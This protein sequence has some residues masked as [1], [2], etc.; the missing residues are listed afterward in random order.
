MARKREVNLFSQLNNDME[1]NEFLTSK[2][3]VGESTKRNY[4][5]NFLINSHLTVLDVYHELVGPCLTLRPIMEKIKKGKVLDIVYGAN[6]PKIKAAFTKYLHIVEE[7]HRELYDFDE[8]IPSEVHALKIQR[9]LKEEEN[10]E[11]WAQA[12]KDRVEMLD[13][14]I[15]LMKDSASDMGLTLFMPH[16]ADV[17]FKKTSEIARWMLMTPKG[18][19][20]IQL[21][22][23]MMPNFC[24]QLDNPI[25]ENILNYLY[26]K[27][28]LA[29][30][31]ATDP[32]A[33]TENVLHEFICKVTEPQLKEIEE[34]GEIIVTDELEPSVL[35]P[36][37]IYLDEVNEAPQNSS[38]TD[39]NRES[40]NTISELDYSNRSSSMTIV[41]PT[42]IS[43]LNIN[44][45]DNRSL[46]I[47]PVWTPKNQEGNAVLMSTFFR[48]HFDHILP[49]LKHVEP[50]Q[51]L[52]I[53]PAK[54]HLAI[55][56]LCSQNP[57]QLLAYG[58]FTG[59]RPEQLKLI[60]KSQEKFE[61]L[62]RTGF[63]NVVMKIAEN[64]GHLALHLM[65]F[66]PIFISHNA[67]TGIKDCEKV[68]NEAFNEFS[69]KIEK[70]K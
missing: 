9:D 18:R 62:K 6:I 61:Q 63:E 12:E 58:Y 64:I 15:T 51:L 35:E 34:D 30:L 55:H 59:D 60:C 41:E 66:N 11:I 67:T 48:S 20:F 22:P 65:E 10:R 42:K 39:V 19:T 37:I 13:K 47:P 50:P 46:V 52:M 56:E 14:I 49:P 4:H 7:E 16:V 25:D 27:D 43:S 38:I 57:N 69:D 24:H 3:L 28:I 26:G 1:F 68:F 70:K 31:W 33:S 23:N 5:L 54:N 2:G 45:D 40:R 44:E 53:L 36:L 29:V 32:R 8:M 21:Q 17:G